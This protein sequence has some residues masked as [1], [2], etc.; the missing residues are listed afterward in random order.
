MPTASNLHGLSVIIS[1]NHNRDVDFGGQEVQQTISV[2]DRVLFICCEV[3]DPFSQPY[4]PV[5]RMRSELGVVHP[6]S[7]SMV[8]CM[9]FQA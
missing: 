7:S 3:V 1:K 8:D 9:T 4:G 5:K 6:S 2:V